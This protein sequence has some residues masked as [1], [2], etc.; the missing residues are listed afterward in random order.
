MSAAIGGRLAPVLG[1]AI[2]ITIV[3]CADDESCTK[4]DIPKVLIVRPDGTGDY[5]TVQAAIAAA[6]SGHV[7][8][9]A[10]GVFTGNG[11]RDIDFLG[12]AITVRSQSG[13]PT[14]CIIDC[15]TEDWGH[16]RGFNFHSGE[17]GA[18]LLK[19]VAIRNG[20]I[21][22]GGHG[23]GIV[24]VDAS[25]SISNCR[26]D[27]CAAWFGG[28]IACFRASPQISNCSF[29]G[30]TSEGDGGGIYCDSSSC[31]KITD[32]VF[33]RNVSEGSGGGLAQ[34]CSLPQEIGSCTFVNN[35]ASHGGGAYL[36]GVRPSL[37]GCTFHLNTAFRG[38]GVQCAS[39]SPASVR[40]SI[41]AFTQ[42]SEAVSVPDGAVCPTLRCC[43]LYG[44]DGGDWEGCIADQLGT[45]GN[46][47]KDPLFCDPDHGD[48]RLKPTSPCGPDS[49]ECGL[50]GAWPVGR[51]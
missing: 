29:A 37:S 32:C 41:I 40:S 13:D 33:T 38:G 14:T 11:N 28:G 48:L 7:I 17:T 23:G 3:G 18:A 22:V 15:S 24:C 31:P 47:S 2:C 5:P 46:I 27:S 26:V 51:E 25:P 39:S 36:G 10:D 4:P 49:S 35:R 45:D 8:E 1:L 30:N 20:F 16:H 6:D 21:F 34:Y 12:K 44:N 50:M 42:L 19:G 43:N 9:L